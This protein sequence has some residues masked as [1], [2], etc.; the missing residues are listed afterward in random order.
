[1]FRCLQSGNFFSGLNP[2]V[3]QHDLQNIP[4][5]VERCASFQIL[6]PWQWQLGTRSIAVYA[7]DIL[8]IR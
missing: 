2:A 3:V 7:I 5:F 4:A 8:R 1:M 6:Q